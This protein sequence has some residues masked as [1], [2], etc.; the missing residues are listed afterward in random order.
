MTPR[1]LQTLL[2]LVFLILGAWCLFFPS[3]VIAVTFRPEFATETKTAQFLMGCFGAQAVL[4][5]VL[6]LAARFTAKTFLVFGLVGSIPFFGFNLWFTLVDPVLNAWMLLDTAGNLGILVC[7]LWGW[8]LT[9]R[10]TDRTE[11]GT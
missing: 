5:G 3:T 8:A 7:G 4:A 1:I 10:E 6:I 2:A 11:R 9:R